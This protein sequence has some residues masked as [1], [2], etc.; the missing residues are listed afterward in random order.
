MSES[1]S[2]QTKLQSTL[3]DSF[4]DRYQLSERLGT[5]SYGAV[6]RARDTMLA[7]D[8][9]IKQVRFDLFPTTAQVEEVKRRAQREAKMA[10]KLRH[11]GIVAVHDIVHTDESTLIIMEYVNG[12]TLETKLKKSGRLG[13]EETLAIIGQTADALDHAHAQGVVHRDIKPANLMIDDA[14]GVKIADF[15]IAK[16]QGASEMTS[17]ITA[18]GNVLGTPYYMSPEQARGEDELDGRSD[19]FSLGCV[20]YECLAGRKPFRGKSVIDVLLNVVNHE[21]A[22][23]D[24]RALEL[25]PDIEPVLTKA[26]AKSSDARY[27]TARELVESL[28]AVPEPTTSAT[29][30]TPVV[31]KRDPGASFNYDLSCQGSLS[32]TTIAEIIRDIQ[33]AG[34]TGILHLQR[35]ELSKRLYFLDGSIVFANSDLESDRLGQM[36]IDDGIIDAPIYERAAAAMKR[37]RQRLGRTLVALGQ[38]EEERLDAIVSEQI[39]RIVYSVFSW[40]SGTY[41]FETIEKPVEDDIA[42]QLATNALVFEGIRNMATETTV[43]Q[44]LGSTDRI[45]HIVQDVQN[46]SLPLTSAEGFVLSRVD[47]MTS[48]AEITSISPLG[49]TQTLR[50]IYGLVSAGILRL[51]DPSGKATG[52]VA[53]VPEGATSPSAE[54][55]SASASHSNDV[56]DE[57]RAKRK[58]I[59][60]ASYYRVL[61]V[62]STD[63]PAAI[64]KAYYA[65]AKKFHPD[66]CRLTDDEALKTELEEIV[67]KLAEAYDVLSD[68]QKRR[69]YDA[70]LALANGGALPRAH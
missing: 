41:G 42:L 45:L 40:D 67:A 5:G 15:G 64:K 2:L 44:A 59:E 50:C 46:A 65:L 21:P 14:G 57:I 24:V 37:S 17:N 11:P 6:Y 28:R 18:T 58:A 47:G 70:K 3:T 62:S 34:K 16:A 49:D 48:I 66:H 1:N 36:L 52:R 9:A 19:L 39:Q 55:A 31:T 60:H 35:N 30:S 69:R 29:A 32:E 20:A 56:H 12:E 10:A 27:Q 33:T 4:G 13:L 54:A 22:E 53:P 8:V 61:G 7:R 25:H 23:L 38:I 63:T 68:P 26:L 43:R 51:E